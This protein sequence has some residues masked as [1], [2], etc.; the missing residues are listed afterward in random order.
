MEYRIIEWF[1]KYELQ[2]KFSYFDNHEKKIKWKSCCR[3]TR[4]FCER[5]YEMR[6]G[7]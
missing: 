6:K 1:G 5:I 3:G 7:A 2:K 4:E